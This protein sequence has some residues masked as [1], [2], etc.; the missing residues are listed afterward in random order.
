[1]R[2]AGA[3]P[4]ALLSLLAGPA[5]AQAPP[6]PTGGRIFGV[7]HDG[8]P[9]APTPPPRE[10]VRL[11]YTAVPG[12]PDEQ[13]L[14]SALAARLGYDPVVPAADRL[15]RVAL[16]QEGRGFV[17]RAELLDQTGRVLWSR[18]PLA[19]AD[20][21]A[22][23]DVMGLSLKFAIDPASSAAQAAA[24]APDTVVVPLILSPPAPAA[25]RPEP[26]PP[27]SSPRP[28]VRLGLRG[29]GA[30]ATAPAPTGTIAA[31]AGLGWTYFSLALEGRFDVPVTGAVDGG[32]QARSL[33]AAGSL[34]PCGHYSW[35]AGCAVFSAGEMWV[36]G[37]STRRPAVGTSFYGAVGPRVG[38]E[39]PLPPLPALALRAS[40]DVL[41][42]VHPVTAL[43][44]T[45]H[46]WSAPTFAGLLGGGFVVKL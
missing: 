32:V 14:R 24:P 2:P 43:V 1:M 5:L 23:V 30:L 26:P 9:P 13:S 45:T 15:L 19:D 42:T 41:V 29:G 20:C 8:L 21:R 25:G 46:V 37:V 22:L 7:Q 28:R 33:I 18:P 39:W 31:D 38:V 34:V 12:C 16:T 17:A 6:P 27:A 36:S 10:I 35:F 44:D 40:L 11:Q 4:L 3:L